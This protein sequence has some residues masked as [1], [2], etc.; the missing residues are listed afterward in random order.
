M[1]KTALLLFP[2]AVLAGCGSKDAPSTDGASGTSTAPPP[3]ELKVPDTLRHDGMEYYGLEE[4]GT[5]PMIERRTEAGKTTTMV[6]EMAT[7]LT[8]VEGDVATYELTFGGGL[9]GLGS[10]IIELRKDGVY[11]VSNSTFTNEKPTLDLP[12]TCK[13]GESW[14]VDMKGTMAD[15]KVAGN[16]TYKIAR[17]EKVRVPGGE[18]DALVVESLGTFTLNGTKFPLKATGWYVKGKGMVKQEAVATQAGQKMVSV[19]ELSK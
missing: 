12:S 14:K 8:K 17:T 13:V 18:F 16:S 10:T 15:Q 11:L 5:H 1:A 3:A 6:G 7:K 9:N 4:P 19:L 2:L